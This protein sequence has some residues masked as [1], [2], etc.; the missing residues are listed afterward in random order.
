MPSSGAERMRIH[1][2][3][4]RA[5]GLREVQMWVIDTSRPGFAEEVARDAAVIAE[6]DRRDPDL[7]AD[8]EAAAND[9]DGWT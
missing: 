7:M 8:L 6:A 2:A 5:A 1:R 4:M 3:K 9:I